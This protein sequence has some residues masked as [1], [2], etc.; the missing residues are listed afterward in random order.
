MPARTTLRDVS[1]TARWVAAYRAQESARPDALFR[2]PLAALLAGPRGQELARE[3]PMAGGGGGWPI[4]TRTR[5]V[6]D[7]VLASIREGCSTV[8]NL[9]AG[10][11][12]R[13]YRL[14]LPPTLR[15]VEADL[16]AL[17][18]EKE[19]LLSGGRPG[20]ALERVATDLA[21]PAR[22]AALLDRFAPDGAR[23]LVL[24]EG[25][26]VYLEDATVT[27]LARE[28]AARAG[29]A[30]WVLDLVSP[31][32]LRL[33]GRRHGAA[34]AGAPLRFGP[35]NGVA[36]FEHLGWRA[37]ELQPV[38]NEAGRLRRVPLLLRPFTWLPPP[39]PRAPGDKHWS[40]VVRLAR[41]GARE[42]AGRPA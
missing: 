17:L 26:L 19:R 1:E 41:A 9:A 23:V 12:T 20:C 38:F 34:L 2:D 37:R 22:R 33:L 13:P 35:A 24:T 4:V 10:F 11:D 5:L 7:L 30:A 6:D 21:D 18:E 40:A 25:L 32:M 14:A 28:L 36:F 8:L 15:W 31:G 3:I 39:D 29:I 42:E 27:A 16:P